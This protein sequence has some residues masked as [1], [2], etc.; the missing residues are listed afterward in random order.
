MLKREGSIH[1]HDRSYD[2]RRGHSE[3]EKKKFR[4]F[5]HQRHKKME[6]GEEEN[7]D[8]EAEGKQEGKEHMNNILLIKS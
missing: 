4:D 6:G 8:E 3:N 2:L 1:D 7:E 5:L